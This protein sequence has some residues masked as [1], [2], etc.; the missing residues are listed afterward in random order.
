MARH[1]KKWSCVKKQMEGNPGNKDFFEWVVANQNNLLR[2]Y[3][4]YIEEA[5]TYLKELQSSKK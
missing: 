3:H 5:E 1:R 4:K 2:D